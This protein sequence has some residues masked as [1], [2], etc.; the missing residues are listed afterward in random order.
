MDTEHYMTPPCF[1]YI[2]NIFVQ[3][4]LFIRRIHLYNI[5]CV[6]IEALLIR[7]LW[8][9]TSLLL[10]IKTATQIILIGF[11][12][13]YKVVY[14]IAPLYSVPL[15]GR[16]NFPNALIFFKHTT[17]STSKL[18]TDLFYI[19]GS[20]LKLSSVVF[21]IKLT[22]TSISFYSNLFTNIQ[23]P[24]NIKLSKLQQILHHRNVLVLQENINLLCWGTSNDSSLLLTTWWYQTS[25]TFLELLIGTIRSIGLLL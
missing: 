10:L 8:S 15:A 3:W 9:L 11:T 6:Y 22:K 14:S 17:I 7:P 24:N 23:H 2:D 16:Y 12:K 4:F 1:I 5:R 21:L 18:S 25:L 13:L 20:S 19:L